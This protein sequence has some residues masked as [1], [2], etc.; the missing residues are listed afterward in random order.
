M[1]VEITGTELH[2]KSRSGQ[3]SLPAG[4]SRV[5]LTRLV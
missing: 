4:L 1:G 5:N 3:H 2:E